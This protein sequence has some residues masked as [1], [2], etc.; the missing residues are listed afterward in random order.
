MAA[1]IFEAKILPQGERGVNI[2]QQCDSCCYWPLYKDCNPSWI[3][4]L[5]FLIRVRHTYH[6]HVTLTR[7]LVHTM[8]VIWSRRCHSRH[9]IR[10]TG[11]G[12]QEP[13]FPYPY[14]W[15][16]TQMQSRKVNR[17]ISYQMACVPRIA[18]FAQKSLLSN[19]LLYLKSNGSSACISPY[20][21]LHHTPLVKLSRNFST[22]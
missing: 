15:H 19:V 9:D 14:T 7:L 1:S 2:C 13:R 4:S 6:L 16:L 22:I 20:K 17:R 8:N 10:W 21:F 12:W 18:N 5:Y 3:R 11:R